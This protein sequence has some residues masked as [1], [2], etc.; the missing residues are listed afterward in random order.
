MTPGLAWRIHEWE[1]LSCFSCNK[2]QGDSDGPAQ[3]ASQDMF[4]LRRWES[5]LTPLKSSTVAW[6][7]MLCGCLGL[8]AH[9]WTLRLKKLNWEIAF[10]SLSRWRSFAVWDFPGAGWCMTSFF[11]VCSSCLLWLLAQSHACCIHCWEPS[12]LASIPPCSEHLWL[13]V[14]VLA[15]GWAGGASYTPST[16]LTGMTVSALMLRNSCEVY[17]TW[18]SV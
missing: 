14:T 9:S 4:I 5:D 17:W 13:S 12:P 8:S 3:E 15:D 18:C 6:S 1:A 2:I 10:S 16:I 7:L 11:R